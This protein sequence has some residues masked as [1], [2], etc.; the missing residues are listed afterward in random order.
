MEHSY[1]TTARVDNKSSEANHLEEVNRI[2][3]KFNRKVFKKSKDEKDLIKLIKKNLDI[4]FE[5]R[6]VFSSEFDFKDIKRNKS[7]M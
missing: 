5:G 6:V 2:Q 7:K 4:P 1:K 3:S